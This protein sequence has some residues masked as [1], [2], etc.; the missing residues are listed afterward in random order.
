MVS[1]G[2][3]TKTLSSVTYR[4]VLSQDLVRMILM[5][6]ALNN[7]DIQA[8]V[9]ENAYLTAPCHK[10][11][12]TRAG[13]EFVNNEG[14]LFIVDRSL[15]GLK[16]SG[17]AFRAFLEEQLDYMGFKSSIVDPDFRMR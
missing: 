2:H 8:A 13:T 16:S 3:T 17:A 5:I 7:I 4:Y 15:Y 10:K 6:A 14:K 9:I 1:G 12:W 11:I